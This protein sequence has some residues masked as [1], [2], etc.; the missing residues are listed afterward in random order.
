MRVPHG[1]APPLH[2]HCID[3]AHGRETAVT[4]VP[5]PAPHTFLP[6]LHTTRFPRTPWQRHTFCHL[7]LR[8]DTWCAM[9]GDQQCHG[10]YNRPTGG[11]IACWMHIGRAERTH[12]GLQRFHRRVTYAHY[13]AGRWRLHLLHPLHSRRLHWP[14]LPARP[15]LPPTR[16]SRWMLSATPLHSPRRLFWGRF[17]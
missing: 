13:S 6:Q 7:H 17:V 14:L 10:W 11:C 1:P 2:A 12:P 3:G 9:P 16:F 8:Y 4:C 15:G 5:A